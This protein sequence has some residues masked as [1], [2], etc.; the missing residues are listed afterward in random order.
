MEQKNK[1]RQRWKNYICLFVPFLFVLY[2]G[3]NY[4]DF[5]Y[6]SKTLGSG[7]KLF[8]LLFLWAT[9]TALIFVK[10]EVKES[11]SRIIN[12][13]YV[14]LSPCFIFVNM[15]LATFT[16]GKTFSGLNKSILLFNLGVILV[17]ELICIIIT[18][19]VRLGT[20]ICAF[21]LV[22]L[23]IVNHF[24]YEFRGT[25]VMANDL[26][27]IGT[28]AEVAGQYEIKINLYVLLAL[29][30]LFDFIMA[31]R[32]IKCKPVFSKK[33]Y[34]ICGVIVMI[35]VSVVGINQYVLSD[36]LKTHGANISLFDP[37]RSYQKVGNIAGFSR[38]VNVSILR[39][40]EGYSVEKVKEITSRYESDTVDTTKKKPNVI[41]V[42]NEAFSDLKTLGDF[43]T[44]EDYMPFVH[45]LMGS[46][47][48]VS[49]TS[50][51]SI[52]G[53]QTANTEYEVLTGNSLAFLPTGSVA[54]QL[55]VKN[56]MPSLI[57]QMEDEGY[58]GNSAVHLQNASNYRRDVT[59]PLLGFKN[60]YNYSNVTEIDRVGH[61]ASD[62][63]TYKRMIEDYEDYRKNDSDSP[64]MGYVLTVQNH[65]PFIRREGN[66]KIDER[67]S[68]K[69]KDLEDVAVYLNLIKYSDEAFEELVN[70]FKQTDE[71]TVILMTGDHQPRIADGSMSALTKGKWKNWDDEEMMRH[72]YS[73]PFV[74]WANYD[75]GEKTVEQTSMN[76]LQT[77][78]LDTI[79]SE[80]TGFQ[81]Y[82]QDF[83]KEIPVLTGNGY[84][85][86]DGKFY[87]LDDE[88]SPYYSLLQEYAILQYNDL[89]DTDNRDND[90]FDLQK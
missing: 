46:K 35:L 9:G 59:Y 24:V 28:A 43:E 75:I 76:Y 85:G 49:G 7:M 37:M 12:I 5:I 17:L 50:Y 72:R 82:Q 68:L 70:Y 4:K 6:N 63:G 80:M 66:E 39:K 61:Y 84:V 56:A 36:F 73:I 40:P 87:K 18:N 86:A 90:F 79:G 67:I 19:R 3:L 32:V 25:P 64:Y 30:L 27:T 22:L 55:Y 16:V 8:I 41:V 1:N 48:C 78:L 53:G 45:S 81:K 83:Q 29:L 60:F 34:R 57:T 52:V 20:D 74:I 31:G 33:R 23:N 51:A 42:I 21:I 69:G 62:A 26:A 10:L 77:L 71:P 13:L 15:E 2:F 47:N 38:S 58:I 65:S 54:F 88:T 11:V 44:N 14:I 89:V